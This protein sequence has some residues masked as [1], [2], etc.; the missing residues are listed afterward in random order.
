MPLYMA[1]SVPGL[2]IRKIADK[3]ADY[4]IIQTQ[5]PTKWPAWPLQTGKNDISP[6]ED[7]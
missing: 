7:Q 2:R 5:T 1:T 6:L 4:V 3:M